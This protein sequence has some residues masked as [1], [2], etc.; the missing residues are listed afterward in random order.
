M[1]VNSALRGKKKNQSLASP[2]CRAGR[3]RQE[4]C[5]VW[6]SSWTHESLSASVTRGEELAAHPSNP[7]H[8]AMLLFC[9]HCVIRCVRN[10]CIFF[11]A[12]NETR[13]VT[14]GRRRGFAYSISSARV[15]RKSSRFA[16]SF[17]EATGWSLR[18][19]CCVLGGL[20]H[21]GKIN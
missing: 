17:S 7:L 15:C 11:F 3:R 21:L 4:S 10:N 20:E 13:G 8:S 6:C 1:G 18:S 19:F 12:K 9:I 2:R 16:R 14:W 5:G